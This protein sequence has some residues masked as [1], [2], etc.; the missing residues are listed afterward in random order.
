MEAWLSQ[1]G[2]AYQT[3]DIL[4][5]P[6]SMEEFQGIASALGGSKALL[7]SGKVEDPAYKANIA[8]REPSEDELL[9]IFHRYPDLLRK[10]ILF[11]GERAVVGYAPEELETV[12]TP[13]PQAG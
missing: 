2:I 7:N 11:D 3:I 12:V 1:N 6:P 8:G 10:P 4:T 9:K 5:Q 13:A